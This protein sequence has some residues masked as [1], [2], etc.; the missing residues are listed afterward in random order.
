MTENI[1]PIMP[2]FNICFLCSQGSDIE[3][4]G[5]EA[6]VEYGAELLER[7]PEE[8]KEQQDTQA[9]AS[10][11]KS[12][13]YISH[14]VYLFPVACIS[15]LVLSLHVLLVKSENSSVTQQT[16]MILKSSSPKVTFFSLSEVISVVR[17]L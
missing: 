16:K 1:F 17:H 11:S 15:F 5:T 3:T 9:S 8:E 10:A 14:F 13:V 4:L 6:L 12:H 7:P 2:S